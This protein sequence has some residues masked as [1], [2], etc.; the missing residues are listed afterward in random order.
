MFNSIIATSLDAKSLV[1]IFICALIFGLFIAIGHK[2]TSNMDYSK[3]FLIT[4]AILPFLVSILIIM[5][6]GNLG[7][8]VAVA[9]A[10][11][12]IR[13]RSVPGNSKEIISVF[14]AMTVGI[15]LGMGYILYSLLVTII[16]CLFIFVLTKSKFGNK[17]NEQLLKI[18]IPEDLDYNNVFKDI[19]EKYTQSFQLLKVKTTNLGSLYEITY[20]IVIDN[21]EKNLIDELRTK[22]ANLRIS[23]ERELIN[24]ENL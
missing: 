4:L 22:N 12:L 6:N 19:L 2:K 8:G 17:K 10:F 20:K 16:G 18:T 23:L 21:Q 24:A 14:F 3:N 5:V 15:C 7:A 1:L 11:S 9:G 13:F